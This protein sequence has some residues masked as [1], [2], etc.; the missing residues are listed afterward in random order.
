M[1]TLFRNVLAVAGLA[2]ATQAVAEVTFYEHEDF[3][4]RSFCL[5][6]TRFVRPACPERISREDFGTPRHFAR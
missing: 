5:S 1:N 3:K 6:S 2:V 4:G